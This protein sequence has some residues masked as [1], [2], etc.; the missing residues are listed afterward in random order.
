MAAPTP[1]ARQSPSG[2]RINEG[3]PVKLTLSSDPDIELWEISMKMPGIDNGDP[4]DITTQH[5]VEAK[6]KAARYLN[7]W[8]NG[9][10][11]F[12]LDPVMLT[13]ARQQVGRE[14]TLT[15][16]I[17][18]GSTY[19]FYGYIKSVD[20]DEWGEGTRPEATADI[21]V[22]NFDP[23]NRVEALPVFTDVAGT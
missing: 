10:V 1:T 3:F 17:P 20:F 22:T 21:V 4:I 6:T 18:D 9:S 13:R 15:A 11:K 2:I 16:T 5:N 23:S 8:T 19:A 7:E 12:A 14:Q